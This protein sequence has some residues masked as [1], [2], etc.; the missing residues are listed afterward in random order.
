MKK[1]IF[2][3]LLLVSLTSICFAETI[4]Y[5]YVFVTEQGVMIA[6]FKDKL[7]N[8]KLNNP[9][10]PLIIPMNTKQE[11]FTAELAL[12]NAQADFYKGTPFFYV[13]YT[14]N[15]DDPDMV[16]IDLWSDVIAYVRGAK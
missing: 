14:K 15:A 1:R 12:K 9:Y 7:P 4:K 5:R 8:E 16:C 3:I 2:I 10:P 13:D 11:R 6:D